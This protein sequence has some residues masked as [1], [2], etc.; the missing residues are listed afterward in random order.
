ML[1]LPP[2]SANQV[3]P[4]GVTPQLLPNPVAPLPETL[5]ESGRVSGPGLAPSI[6]WAQQLD[7]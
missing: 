5:A 4:L 6:F 7:E 3:G 2:R 1:L